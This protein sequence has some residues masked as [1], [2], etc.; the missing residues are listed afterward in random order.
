MSDTYQPLRDLIGRTGIP[1]QLAVEN[2]MRT[3]GA[4]YGIEV[5]QREVPWANGFIDIIV[6]SSER[7]FCAV[8]C[9]RVTDKS[10]S[11]VL[12]GNSKESATRCRIECFNG[13]AG[14]RAGQSRV[15]CSEWNMMEPSPES[16]FCILPKDTPIGSLE[17][18]CKD[19]LASC[20]NLLENEDELLLNNEYALMIPV[21]VTN[22]KLYTC[23]LNV[24]SISLETG[25]PA[26]ASTEFKPVEMIRFRKSLVNRRSNSYQTSPMVLSDWTVD[27]E[28]TVFVVSPPAI[29]R[30]FAGFRSL[31][32]A[33]F[34]GIPNE[35]LNPPS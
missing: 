11:F 19:L 21:I 2:A 26:E 5:V 13:N 15:F 4:T 17:S 14:K 23:K 24:D 20:H 30:F 33:T 1:F 35:F 27:R 6:K 22:A 7:V 28:R 18:V 9:K 3:V 32:P 31:A 25:L 8:E 16:E 34:Q 10:W 29:D 12:T